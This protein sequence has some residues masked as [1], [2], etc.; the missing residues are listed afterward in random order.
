MALVVLAAVVTVA[1]R[2]RKIMGTQ[3]EK[4]I[5]NVR[6]SSSEIV[7]S[8]EIGMKREFETKNINHVTTR[9]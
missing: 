9:Y 8:A 3:S 1:E 4:F 2:V 5:V 6:N 7:V